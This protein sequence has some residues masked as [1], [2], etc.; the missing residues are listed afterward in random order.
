ME[1]ITRGAGHV[2]QLF[3][4]ISGVVGTVHATGIGRGGALSSAFLGRAGCRE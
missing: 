4:L 1:E 3:L 2:Q